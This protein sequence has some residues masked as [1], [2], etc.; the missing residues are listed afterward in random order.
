MSW[1]RNIVSATAL[2]AMALAANVPALA[3][4]APAALV[5]GNGNYENYAD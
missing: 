3:Q 2:T 5:I 4:N 1:R